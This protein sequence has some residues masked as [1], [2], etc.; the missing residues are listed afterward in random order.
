MNLTAANRAIVFD[1]WWH[2]G[3]E[4]QAF[5]RV[6]RIGQTKEV[7]TAKLVAAGSMDETILGMQARKRETIRSAVGN[8]RSDESGDIDQEMLELA[9]LD[10][11][12]DRESEASGGGD[13]NSSSDSDSDCTDGSSDDGSEDE[14]DDD[15]EGTPEA[16]VT[17]GSINKL[18]NRFG[19]P[20]EAQDEESEDDMDLD[21]EDD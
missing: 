2:E 17:V 20:G 7:H 12:S 21:T 8:S 9:R 3:L 1:H 13:D 14:D 15:Y 19:T 5:A 4:R 6:H 11:I 10:D 16:D 18:K